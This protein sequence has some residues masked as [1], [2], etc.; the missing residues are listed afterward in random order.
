[1]IREIGKRIHSSPKKLVIEGPD[2][3]ETEVID[4]FELGNESQFVSDIFEEIFKCPIT[5]YSIDCLYES[6]FWLE[7]FSA[8]RSQ[9]FL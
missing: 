9:M 5:Y 3:K 4:E 1:M 6:V 8:Q 7:K 2:K